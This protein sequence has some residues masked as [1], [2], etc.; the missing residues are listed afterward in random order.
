VLSGAG[1][2]TG[3][4]RGAAAVL[5]RRGDVL[6]S[7][8]QRSRMLSSAF[9]VISERGYEEMS[10]AR[11]TGGAGVSRRT[12]YDLFED[13]EDCFLAVFDESVSRAEEVMVAGYEQG[14]EWQGQIRSALLALL[15]F[16]DGE[17]GTRVLLVVDA[18]KAGPRVQ[19]RRAEIL[20]QL[21]RVLH[22]TGSRARAGRELPRL[23]GE[24][25]VGAVLSV[26][27]TRLSR[28]SREP[29]VGLVNELMGV[30][31]LAYLGLAAAHRELERPAPRLARAA[32]PLEE[33]D[34]G[35]PSEVLAGL[36]MRVTYRTLLVLTVIGERSGLSN[37]QVAVEAGVTDQG[38]I[39]KLL[40]RLEGLGLIENGSPGQPS[41]EPNEWRLTHRG[42]QVQQ[43]IE[44]QSA[45]RRGVEARQPC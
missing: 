9:A 12:F 4:R 2:S 24:G 34:G 30:I 39:S 16:L 11:I 45:S 6:V 18:W 38:Q 23:T 32:V 37:R 13:R 7:Q 20:G 5:S 3:R 25:V 22:E 33:G 19:E 35:G 42:Q 1:V 27:H 44:A 40:A 31:V 26:L 28:N 10:V 29:L 43:A 21:G 17:P 14:H 15:A 8:A 36:A 41:G